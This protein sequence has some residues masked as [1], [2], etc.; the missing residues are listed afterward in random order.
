MD[1]FKWLQRPAIVPSLLLNGVVFWAGRQGGRSTT[2]AWAA[3]DVAISALEIPASDK[4]TWATATT[5][6][7]VDR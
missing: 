3:I 5:A 2:H 7:R 4:T 6:G 1:V